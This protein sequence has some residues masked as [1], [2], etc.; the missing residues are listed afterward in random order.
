MNTSD[1]IAALGYDSSPNFLRPGGFT[2]ESVGA[3]AHVL[4]KAGAELS[5]RGAYTLQAPGGAIPLVYVC[6]V[7][8]ERKVS[9]IH[10]LV[11]NQD[12]VPCLVLSSPEG[13]RVF[14]GFD[15]ESR[16]PGGNRGI[17]EPLA[18]EAEI[19]S[20]LA[21]FSAE[22][23]DSGKTWDRLASKVSP[24]TRLNVRLLGNLKKLD[25]QLQAKDLPRD[26]SHALIGKYVYL[27][28]LRD[29]G[30]L[31][32]KKL[33]RWGI[34]ET[35]IFGPRATLD[36]LKEVSSNLDEWLN[37]GVFPID[38]SRKSGLKG[39][40]VKWV[41]G[42]FAGEEISG[43]G[44]HQLH[45]DF[46]AYDFSF[47]PVE[48]LSVVY[49]QFLHDTPM[50]GGHGTA[51]KTGAYYTPIPV[52]N[53][54]L[55][56]L[57][58][59]LPL[60]RGMRVFDPT[61]GSGAFLV[62]CFRR[63]IEREFPN[64]SKPKPGQLRELLQESIFG[65]DLDPDACS[66]AE[67]SLVLTLLD[68]V[69][70]PDLE[71]PFHNFKLPS[72]RGENIVYG[73][74]FTSAG[75]SRA[76]DQRY[77][78]VLGNPPWRKI[79]LIKPQKE[80][81]SAAAWIK[82]HEKSHPVGNNEVA[83]AIA[84]K[85][86][87]HLAPAGRAALLL[88]AMSLFE[89]AAKSFRSR[90]FSRFDV[91]TVVNFSN[92]AE[93]LANGRF[94]VPAA[95]L[96]FKHGGDHDAE[97][98]RVFSPMVANQEVTRPREKGKRIESWVITIDSSDV[99]EIP[100][101]SVVSGESLP[102][103]IAAWGCPADAAL[104][105][106]L[107][108]K[109][110]SLGQLEV[111]GVLVASEG[112]QNR[113]WT[114]SEAL[115]EVPEIVGKKTF[116]AK[117]LAKW[118]RLFVLPVNCIA[119]ISKEQRWVRRGRVTL[120]LSICRPPHVIVSAARNFAIFSNEFIVVP[121][122]QIGIVS[123]KDDVRFLKA[124][125]LFL[126]SDFARYHEFLSSSELGVKRD[127]STLQ[128]LRNIALPISALTKEQLT[129]WTRLHDR[130]AKTKPQRLGAPAATDGEF[131]FD[132][133]EEPTGSE[134]LIRELNELVASALGLSA[135]EQDL[136][137]SLVETRIHLNDGNVGE[138]AVRPP[139]DEDLKVY[140]R[141]LKEDL[142][143][144]LGLVSRNGHDIAV[145]RIHGA[146]LLRVAPPNP[147]Q[148]RGSIRIENTPTANTLEIAE[149]FAVLKERHP[150]WTYFRR[151]LRYYHGDETYLLKPPQRFQW[152]VAQATLDAG[153]LIADHLSTASEA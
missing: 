90:F 64:G 120:P 71:P 112:L 136:I 56:Q 32:A 33:E 84:W 46:P 48:T 106:R 41:S 93:V 29:R 51:R 121:P 9:E 30:I 62:Q 80:F 129:H 2:W 144:F 130:L 115:E 27:H 118:R 53:L 95:A 134:E 21:N 70:P 57:D 55:S 102:W 88:P 141:A 124:L 15:Y 114:T 59:E 8:D 65:I 103:K 131:N 63:L 11:W 6:E 28:Y 13:V 138:P 96:F 152:T 100:V 98:I 113:A 1:T 127:R 75:P 122:R 145:L 143:G 151:A 45:L 22:S 36:G 61:C 68:Y 97:T 4:R 89:T 91:T 66:V 105:D 87:E 19:V 40:H 109:F 31:S 58:S 147:P 123:P 81:V 43:G 85:V 72:L 78:W 69:D 104:L 60:K 16:N 133:T 119:E 142:D 3:F 77:D 34:E 108:R 137:R 79:S 12:I 139:S 148:T 135:R 116:D 110:P 132:N 24:E 125:A 52:V 17:L 44:D 42:I 74:F 50:A 25:A 117:Q 146:L 149:T 140:C 83:R 20:R 73:D 86:E 128:S 47:I 76:Q 35:S 111:D 18:R 54:M 5:L 7:A 14:S 39:T 150:Q 153:S 107:K 67:L 23:I 92:L 126:S 49:E 26:T 101:S 37:G 82:E 99:R 10:R 94:R 38:F